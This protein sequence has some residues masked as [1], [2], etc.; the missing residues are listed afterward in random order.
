MT[1]AEGESLEVQEKEEARTDGEQTRPGRFYIP[2]TDIYEKED[3]LYVVMEM[4]G[5]SKD[6]IA[7]RVED[8]V[9]RVEGQ[10]D[11]ANYRDMR[12]VYTEY[13]IGHFRRR[14]SLSSK[15]DRER[16]SASTDNGVLTVVLPKAEEAKPRRITIN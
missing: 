6:G 16:I 9:L 12:P 11:F 3:A 10:I 5:V 7:V 14:F 15:I 13:N 8:D 2:K 1:P 4:P